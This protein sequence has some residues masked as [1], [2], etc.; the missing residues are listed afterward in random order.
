MF[1]FQ[2]FVR[3][4]GILYDLKLMGR[5]FSITHIKTILES[6]TLINSHVRFNIFLE[7]YYLSSE[8]KIL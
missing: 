8:T 2:T 7:Y 4:S 6:N 5:N 1:Y 3:F